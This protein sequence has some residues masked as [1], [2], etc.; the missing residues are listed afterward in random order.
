AAVDAA[1]LLDGADALGGVRA[2]LG[3]AGK[4][5]RPLE[6]AEL[7][8]LLRDLIGVDL[9]G[10]P[11]E[12]DR[13]GTALADS[14]APRWGLSESGPRALALW[15]KAAALMLPVAS[16]AEAK[17]AA[18]LWVADRGKPRALALASGQGRTAGKGKR[19]RLWALV[20]QR[21]ILAAGENAP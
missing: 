9:L 14:P 2:F 15:G 18:E 21:L 6:P 12:Q 7:G 16:A 20:K 4:L 1:L 11:A 8:R 17:K 3:S 5:A 19:L 10:A 13:A